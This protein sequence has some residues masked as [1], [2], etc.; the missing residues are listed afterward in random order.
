MSIR[1]G[2]PP[3]YFEATNNVVLPVIPNSNKIYPTIAPLPSNHQDNYYPTDNNLNLGFRPLPQL[4]VPSQTNLQ[5][6]RAKK[7]TISKLVIFAYLVAAVL[8]C[9]GIAVAIY[10]IYI[11]IGNYCIINLKKL[12]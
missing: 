4:V 12:L 6:T 9:V 5:N 1:Q 10:Y 7:K 2:A 3:D 8:I 11:A